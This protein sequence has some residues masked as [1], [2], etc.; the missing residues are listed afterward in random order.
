MLVC[1]LIVPRAAWG[2]HEA[3]HEQPVSSTTQHVHH[4]EHSH[5]VVVGTADGQSAH[6]E[7]GEKKLVHDHLPA[8]VLSAMAASHDGDDVGNA[9]LYSSRH[10]IDRHRT[11]EPYAASDSLLRPPRTA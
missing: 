4:G 3:G 2:A 6:H 1:A 11:G 5:E 10:L 8:D 7:D 9:L